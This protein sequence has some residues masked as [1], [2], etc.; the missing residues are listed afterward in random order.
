VLHEFC[1]DGFH[2]T[3][4]VAVEEDACESSSF[5]YLFNSYFINAE[6]KPN[7]LIFNQ[8]E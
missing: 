8:R 4:A 7:S 6:I 2:V 5:F 1:I 3:T